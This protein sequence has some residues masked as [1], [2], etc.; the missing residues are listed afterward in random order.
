MNKLYRV[1][2]SRE[3]Y[4]LPGGQTVTGWWSRD[5]SHTLNLLRDIVRTVFD[6]EHGFPWEH[7]LQVLVTSEEGVTARPDG[8]RTGPRT[9]RYDGSE[10]FVV[11]CGD[12]TVYG[13]QE[14]AR[15]HGDDPDGWV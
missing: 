8:P 4:G 9:L 6:R 13:W 3:T 5:P 2:A 11:S 1:L 15:L 14:F 10:V 7:E 12:V